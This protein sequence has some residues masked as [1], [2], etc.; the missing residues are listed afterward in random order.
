MTVVYPKM[1]KKL[2]KSLNCNLVIWVISTIIESS[3]FCNVLF[4]GISKNFND[5]FSIVQ[6]IKLKEEPAPQN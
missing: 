4:V 1:L 3:L 2:P 6:M 5:A